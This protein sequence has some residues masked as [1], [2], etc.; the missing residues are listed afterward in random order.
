MLP[1]DS[2][3]DT[4]SLRDTDG[5]ILDGHGVV[6]KR[7]DLRWH[8]SLIGWRR[9]RH[10]RYCVESVQALSG[11]ISCT[12]LAS[13]NRY[14]AMEESRV[15]RQSTLYFNDK[16]QS[17]RDEF[18]K[19]QEYAKISLPPTGSITPRQVC[20]A[21]FSFTRPYSKRLMTWNILSWARQKMW[22]SI[23]GPIG[24]RGVARNE[25]KSCNESRFKNRESFAREK[26]SRIWTDVLFS[27]EI[28]KMVENL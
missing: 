14:Q 8:T 4:Y 10:S 25:S 28:I 6:G 9:G 27:R 5:L 3:L 17:H 18:S 23:L 20:G 7:E 1:Y 13:M 19:D 11:L 24:D 12:V 15:K 2:A 26:M 16:M 22:K 21:L